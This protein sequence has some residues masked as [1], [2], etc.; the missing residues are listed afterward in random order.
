[1][2]NSF[3]GQETEPQKSRGLFPNLQILHDVLGWLAGLF[4]LTEEEQDEAGVCL[5][6]Q[7]DE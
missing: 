1:M 3:H 2:D 4:E 6:D 7:H 5:G